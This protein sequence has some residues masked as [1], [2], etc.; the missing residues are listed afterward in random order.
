M[1]IR[2]FSLF[3]GPERH[4]GTSA[5]NNPGSSKKETHSAW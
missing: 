4:D 2:E 3:I 5:E 1:G